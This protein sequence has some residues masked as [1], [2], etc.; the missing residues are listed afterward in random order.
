MKN[1]GAPHTQEAHG[2]L[3]EFA[4]RTVLSGFLWTWL[5]KLDISAMAS[6]R[7]DGQLKWKL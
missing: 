5:D 1:E 3:R 7:V 2:R 4:E 6:D